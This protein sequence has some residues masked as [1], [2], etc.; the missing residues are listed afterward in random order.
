MTCLSKLWKCRSPWSHFWKQIIE[1]IFNL[2]DKRGWPKC[3]N[4][5]EF[6]LSSVDS[7]HDTHFLWSLFFR[8]LTS[9]NIFTNPEIFLNLRW[10]T[11]NLT[12]S[13]CQTRNYE[14]AQKANPTISFGNHPKY[15]N[16]AWQKIR[17]VFN[18][19]AH[20]GVILSDAL[21]ELN[22]LHVI[23]LHGC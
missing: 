5:F 21:D 22:Y 15:M 12:K 13:W 16:T 18:D 9:V 14:G 2:I 19:V 4:P 8:E 23:D 20:L 17:T 7:L 10:S 1:A 6:N 11:D 3:K